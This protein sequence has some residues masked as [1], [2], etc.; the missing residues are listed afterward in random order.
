[1]GAK[2]MAIDLMLRPADMVRGAHGGEGKDKDSLAFNSR[3]PRRDF[4]SSHGGGNWEQIFIS[5]DAKK[6]KWV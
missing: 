2:K 4:Y 1:M 6:G 3:R 5:W